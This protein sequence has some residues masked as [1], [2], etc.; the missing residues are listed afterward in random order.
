MVFFCHSLGVGVGACI[1]AHS[2]FLP[3]PFFSEKSLHSQFVSIYIIVNVPGLLMYFPPTRWLGSE[4]APPVFTTS[5]NRPYR[6]SPSLWHGQEAW[7]YKNTLY[8][9]PYRSLIK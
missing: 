7:L 8:I 5:A 6:G 2:S 9:F 3:S 1:T 4:V